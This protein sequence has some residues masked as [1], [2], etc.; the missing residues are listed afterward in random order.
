MDLHIEGTQQMR[1]RLVFLP[2][3]SWELAGE[4]CIGID[5]HM[6]TNRIHMQA[7]RTNKRL[8]NMTDQLLIPGLC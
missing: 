7:S 1:R 3:D 8:K 2:A 5:F 4:S 6:S